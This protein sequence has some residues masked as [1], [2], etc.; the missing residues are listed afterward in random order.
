MPKKHYFGKKI[1]KVV[2]PCWGLFC[3]LRAFPWAGSLERESNP[4]LTDYN[5]NARLVMVTTTVD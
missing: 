4:E 3:G 2:K 5:A 1:P